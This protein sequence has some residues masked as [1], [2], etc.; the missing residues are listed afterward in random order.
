[1]G[2]EQ[3]DLLGFSLGGMV[4]QV[5]VEAEPKL[6]RKLI[7]AGT[8]PAGGRGIDKVTSLTIRDTIKGALTF[9]D[10]K[11][12]LFFTRTSNGRTAARQFLERLKERTDNRDKAISLTAFRAQL[13]AIHAWGLQDPYDLSDIQ[14]PVLVA[15]AKTTG[16]CPAA[17][18]ST[19]LDACQMP[20]S[21]CIVTPDTAAYSSITKS[22]SKRF[23]NSSRHDSLPDRIGK[24]HEG[25][26]PR[27]LWK[28][29]WRAGWRNARPGA[30]GR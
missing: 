3:V 21:D 11:Q 10:P 18:L 13:K 14:Q 22:S 20:S 9:K 24:Y 8:G 19:W 6:V 30:A 12:Y 7:L 25:I 29:R 26:H 23:W 15:T 27:S 5:I 28:Q 16:W 4:A 1:M 17:I 2:F